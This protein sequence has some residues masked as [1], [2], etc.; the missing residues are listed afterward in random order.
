MEP[1]F[2]GLGILGKPVEEVEFI[3]GQTVLITPNDDNDDNLIGGEYMDYEVGIYVVFVAQD[4]NGIA[5]VFQVLDGLSDEN[6]SI[7]EW[8]LILPKFGIFLSS[9]PEREA[10]AAVY[11]DNYDDY[12]IAVVASKT[13]GEPVWTVQM[14]EAAYQP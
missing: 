5:R 7:T 8:D 1:F 12:F 11:W 2:V 9:T 3:L 4:S 10:L 13:S 6:F 14:S